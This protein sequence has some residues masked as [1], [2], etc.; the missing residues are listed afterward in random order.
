MLCKASPVETLA[1][2]RP[3]RNSEQGLG[4]GARIADSHRT[5]LTPIRVFFCLGMLYRTLSTTHSVES[6]MTRS[7]PCK[8]LW[9]LTCML[10]IRASASAYLHH[11]LQ[12]LAQDFHAG[13]RKM[14]AVSV[15]VAVCT[16][17]ATRV[18]AYH[19]APRLHLSPS[20]EC[21]PPPPSVRERMAA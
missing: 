15:E 14:Y 17:I 3:N 13:G 12:L 9:Q 1:P 8:T 19:V 10:Q 18:F 7:C 16:N 20:E 2:S 11:V 6:E 5:L 4:Q 21:R